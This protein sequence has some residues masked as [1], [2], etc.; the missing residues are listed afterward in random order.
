MKGE[1]EKKYK[2]SQIQVTDLK[3]QKKDWDDEKKK[4]KKEDEDR[5]KANSENQTMIDS[6]NMQLSKSIQGR[7]QTVCQ[8]KNDH[9]RK[10]EELYKEIALKENKIVAQKAIDEKLRSDVA[11]LVKLNQN[12][13]SSN[14]ELE[15]KVRVLQAVAGEVKDSNSSSQQSVVPYVEEAARDTKEFESTIKELQKK[16]DDLNRRNSLLTSWQRKLQT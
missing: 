7:D 8:Q 4:R 2:E 12:L 5:K 10:M 15:E 16:V 11:E 9:E 13:K 6:L 14:T 3:K 1:S